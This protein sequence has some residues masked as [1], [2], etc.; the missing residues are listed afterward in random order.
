MTTSVIKDSRREQLVEQIAAQDERLVGE[1]INLLEGDSFLH[2]I[3]TAHN[4]AELVV[5]AGQ[6]GARDYT[7]ELRS[8]FVMAG[9][10]AH[11]KMTADNDEILNLTQDALRASY[12]RHALPELG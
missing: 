8:Y 6:Q 4:A 10:S 5:S 11:E 2:I 1:D 12:L 3:A 9:A 7:T